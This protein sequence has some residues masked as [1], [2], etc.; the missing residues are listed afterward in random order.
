MRMKYAVM[1]VIRTA[2]RFVIALRLLGSY[3]M[4]GRFVK[5]IKQE[6]LVVTL[7]FLINVSISI[8]SFNASYK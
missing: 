7:V 2:K 1:S 8:E 4:K 3:W 5:S 6:Y